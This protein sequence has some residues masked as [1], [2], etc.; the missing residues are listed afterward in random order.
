[1]Q[2]IAFLVALLAL[3]GCAV[4]V[5]SAPA[6]GYDTAT[7]PDS[8]Q[9]VCVSDRPVCVEAVPCVEDDD[10][11]RCIDFDGAQGCHVANVPAGEQCLGDGFIGACDGQGAC[12]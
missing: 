2:T 4:P 7:Y 5:D 12:K 6:N 10:D 11:P 9:T 3:V 1:M 8:W